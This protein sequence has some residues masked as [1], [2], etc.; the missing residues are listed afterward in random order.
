LRIGLKLWSG[1]VFIGDAPEDIHIC[2]PVAQI[3]RLCAPKDIH[4]QEPV[5]QISKLYWF[6]QALNM[7]R[8]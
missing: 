7:T 2:T 1:S 3:R 8:M 4:I 6:T 5:A